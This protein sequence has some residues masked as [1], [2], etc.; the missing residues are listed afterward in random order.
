MKIA[1][2]SR[3]PA[4]YSSVRLMEA[5]KARGHDARIFD[6]THC[7]MNI[8]S[9][10]PSIHYMG[11]DL[12]GY[13]AVIPRIGASITFYGTAVLRQFEVMG[14][15]TLN[16]SAAISRSRD[17]MASSQL[18]ARKGIDL[19]ITAFAHNPDNIEDLI[20]EVGGAP[21]VIKLVEGS[22]GIGVVLAETHNAAHS[23]IQAFMGLNAN[24]MVQEFVQ[25]A[26]GSDIRCFVIG[27]KVV[28]A[29]K[30]QGR[31]G[32]FRS[33][34]HRGGTATLIRL[35]PAERAAAVQAAK[36]MGLD[37][38][39][40]DLLRSKRGPLVMEVNSSPGL[41]GIE[42]TSGKDIAGLMIEHIEKNA[43][44]VKSA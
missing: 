10:K 18:L 3:D 16:K 35:A 44:K 30:R 38:C 42:K 34:L 22:Q 37:V 21:L 19:P 5:A 17:K 9:M 29:M 8:T 12:L 23:V 1:I 33:N 11:E 28:A 25:E 32:E 40:V 39:G 13:D 26:A 41:E 31:E 20:A 7:Y 24:I 2:L 6:P 43:G 4:L 27:D 36:I 14:V 15:Y